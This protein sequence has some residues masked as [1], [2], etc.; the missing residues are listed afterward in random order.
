M[1]KAL[2]SPWAWVPTLY[3]AEGLPYVAVMTLSVIVY[4]RLGL[5][6]AEI[7]LYTSWLYLP[8]TIKPLW[9][10]V[11]DLLK[12]K[13]WWVL[14]MQALVGAALAGVA[15]FIPAGDI[16]VQATMACFWLMAFASATHDIAADGFYMT[17]LPPRG[18]SLFVGIRN[19]FYRLAS[20]I[21]QGVLVM[22]AGWIEVTTGNIALAW[23]LTFYL[24]AALF[25]ALTAWHSLVL[26]RRREDTP[27]RAATAAQ[28]A[29]RFAGTFMSFFR[30]EETALALC[31][32][33]TYRLG[34]AQ[35]VKIASPFLL[36]TP[37]AG[38]LGLGTATVGMIYG[39][40][41]VAALL[42]GGILGGWIVSRQGL[43]RWM[44]PMALAINLP[45]LLYVYLAAAL[46][47]DVTLITACVAVE[48]LGYGFGFTAYTLYLIRIAS[49]SH[50]AAHYAIGTAFMA[51]GMMLPGMP[52]GWI[53]ER[54][55]YTGFFI[56]V[57]ASTLP[58]IAAAVWASRRTRDAE[59]ATGQ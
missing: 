58:G 20:I 35:L 2:K 18:Q 44:V 34:E 11:V 37:E 23:S 31:F 17:A 48:Q 8:W 3:F 12:S 32:L 56:W 28:L 40:V 54:L 33:L 36:D 52:A 51:L 39:T 41:G 45:D 5:S 38:G 9:S 15:F 16:W 25:I 7:A 43:R 14:S 59:P 13:R 19:T 6:N 21:G 57:C 42:A 46:P 53:Q 22:L 55:G 49:G 50:P 24:M 10:P 1:R 29:R 4:K 27:P 26:P 47:A 30:K